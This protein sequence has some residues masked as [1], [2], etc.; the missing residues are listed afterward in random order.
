MGV[1]ELARQIPIRRFPS[2]LDEVVSRRRVFLGREDEMLRIREWVEGLPE[3]DADARTLLVEAGAGMGKTALLANAA[4]DLG[5]AWH[6]V[7]P[8][9]RRDAAAP[10]LTSLF[11]QVAQPLGLGDQVPERAGD[12]AEAAA[13]L[14]G[15]LDIASE[16]IRTGECPPL[17]VIVDNLDGFPDR[18]VEFLSFLPCSTPPGTGLLLSAR[19]RPP[20]SRLSSLVTLS[21]GPLDTSSIAEMSV[22]L[23]HR[24]DEAEAEAMADGLLA[25]TGGRP[26]FVRM[27]LED[28]ALVEHRDGIRSPDDV[29]RLLLERHDGRADE[30]DYELVLALL[31]ICDQ[32]LD[33]VTAAAILDLKPRKVRA[34]F[35]T[36]R[37]YLRFDGDAACFSA[38]QLPEYLTGRLGTESIDPGLLSTAVRRLIQYLRRTDQDALLRYRREQLPELFA[39]LPAPAP[40]TE[41]ARWLEGGDF[42][43]KV[44]ETAVGAAAHRDVRLLLDHGGD[45]DLPAKVF[46]TLLAADDED[47]VIGALLALRAL[48][49]LEFG[50][51]DEPLEALEEHESGWV[52]RSVCR[53]RRALLR[54][55]PPDPSRPTL[56]AMNLLA[57]LPF[58]ALARDPDAGV[59]LQFS[60]SFA[61]DVE[62]LAREPMEF[63]ATT[64][65][66]VALLRAEGIEYVPFYRLVHSVGMDAIVVRHELAGDDLGDL[67]GRSVGYEAGSISRLWLRQLLQDADIDWGAVEHRP[68]VSIEDCSR[69]LHDGRIDAAVLWAPWID[70][71]AGRVLHES[72][73]PT[74]VINDVLCVRSDLTES[75]AA[76]AASLVRMF[77]GFDARAQ[78][79]ADDARRFLGLAPEELAEQILQ[80]SIDAG[81]DI[82]AL[83][84]QLGGIRFLSWDESRELFHDRSD[85][86]GGIHWIAR[87]LA[88][89]TDFPLTGDDLDRSRGWIDAVDGRRTGD[90]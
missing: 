51:L 2:M 14:E 80:R 89:L 10:I 70:A 8:H 72:G 77:D 19:A 33:P 57:H 31:S 30:D 81:V 78:K 23:G 20:S 68:F 13:R 37:P 53:L 54:R 69:A 15:A 43:T 17:V 61:E 55:D 5:A 85:E 18:G 36:I 62:L 1:D 21:L 24:F 86:V 83:A 6:I 41:L 56:L 45:P 40:A 22:S 65:D 4:L 35:R 73:D 74:Q 42:R 39:R 79:A 87:R 60:E 38:P 88:R 90:R 66:V 84:E 9:E 49:E 63:I 82:F 12:P 75:H 46:R 7:A 28:P 29:I 25:V 67:R 52:R 16:R 44:A 11:E 34:Y 58:M 27:I 3:A 32:P 59:R 50:P 47:V 76:A 48:P 26:L 64:L 71:S